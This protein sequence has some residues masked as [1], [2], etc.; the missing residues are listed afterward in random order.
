MVVYVIPFSLLCFFHLTIYFEDY[1]SRLYFFIEIFLYRNTLYFFIELQNI[2]S[3]VFGSTMA[4]LSGSSLSDVGDVAGPSLYSCNTHACT[5]F[6][7]LPVYLRGGFLGHPPAT[8]A[9]P[10]PGCRAQPPPFLAV[11]VDRP[12]RQEQP[13][14]G[15]LFFLSAPPTPRLIPAH[16]TGATQFFCRTL[17]VKACGKCSVGVS[18]LCTRGSSQKGVGMPVSTGAH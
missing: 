13:Q 16:P 17:A 4:G 10:G 2:L 12:G 6:S 14:K 11:R 3:C 15:G 1:C 5:C 7:C 8:A 9:S 18:C